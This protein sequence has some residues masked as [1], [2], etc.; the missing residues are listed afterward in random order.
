MTELHALVCLKEA[1]RMVT[2]KPCIVEETDRTP[3]A[4]VVI[5]DD[6]SARIAT[7]GLLRALGDSVRA[8]V[9]RFV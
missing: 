4:V 1:F 7:E 8:E 5:D 6:D 2:A 9:A 3:L